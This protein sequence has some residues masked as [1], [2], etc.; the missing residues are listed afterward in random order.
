MLRTHNIVGQNFSALFL[1]IVKRGKQVQIKNL[2]NIN[3]SQNFYHWFSEEI[4]NI[5]CRILQLLVLHQTEGEQLS[6]TSTIIYHIY[7]INNRNIKNSFRNDKMIRKSFGMVWLNKSLFLH[8]K[9]CKFFL[10]DGNMG[11]GNPLFHNKFLMYLWL[12]VKKSVN[13]WHFQ[14]A[15]FLNGFMLAFVSSNG[16]LSKIT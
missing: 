2:S 14:H 15:H 1:N 4:W 13:R 5:K 10:I 16:D 6:I 7:Y 8:L 11:M 9:F 12:Y 3:F